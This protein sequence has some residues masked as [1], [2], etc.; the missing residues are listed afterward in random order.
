MTGVVDLSAIKKYAEENRPTVVLDTNVLI[1]CEKA[2]HFLTD[3]CALLDVRICDTVYWEFL[4]NVNLE[5]FRERRTFLASWHRK[6]F[7]QEAMILHEDDAVGSMHARLFILLLHWYSFAPHTILRFLT[8]DLWIAATAIA[9]RFDHVLTENRKDFSSEMFETV[10]TV[11]PANQPVHL[12]RFKREYA[13]ET[14]IQLS[15]TPA[16]DL[17]VEGSVS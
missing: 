11:G 10:V 7:L 17:D 1:R 2:S 16:I 12:L 6:D 8:P 14:W 3:T 9:N 4:R 5:R 15:E 13:R